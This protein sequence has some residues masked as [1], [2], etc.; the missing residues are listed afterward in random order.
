MCVGASGSVDCSGAMLQAERSRA[1]VAMSLSIFNLSNRS[2]RTMVLTF[3]QPLT[4]MSTR[5]FL[6]GYGA[7]SKKG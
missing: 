2:S 4:E 5:R 1:R 3:T 7:A 6:W